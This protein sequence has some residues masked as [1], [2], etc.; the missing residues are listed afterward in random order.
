MSL[1]IAIKEKDRIILGA[2]KQVSTGSTKDHTATKIWE[3]T[4]LE[5]GLMGGVGSARAS[6]IIQY[7]Q[8]INKNFTGPINTEFVIC[9]LVPTI[10][11]TLKANGIA[12]TA[13]EEDSCTMIPNVFIFAYK[14]KA[15]VIW[16]DLSVVEIA[17]YFAIGSGADVAR[18]A[19]F[20][21]KE[22]NPFERIVTCIDAAAESTLFVDDG[23]DLLTTN[24]KSKD[25]KQ[26]AKA[27]GLDLA[28]LREVKQEI[29]VDKKEI[30]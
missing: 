18:G 20:A 8:V 9:A 3:M 1:I 4:E 5:G 12:T 16:H 27:L 17:D 22:K 10:A 2:D 29:E 26:I 15:W 28:L 25:V 14:E 7:S 6:Q 11:A 30:I 13:S 21:T 24:N 23:I 19:L